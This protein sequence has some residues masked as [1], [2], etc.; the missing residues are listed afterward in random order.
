MTEITRSAVGTDSVFDI[1]GSFFSC[2][3]V[4]IH[5]IELTTLAR[6]VVTRR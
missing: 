5:T 4:D 1:N 3:V 2:F 6:P